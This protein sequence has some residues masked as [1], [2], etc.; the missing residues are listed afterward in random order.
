[1]HS[2]DSCVFFK[3]FGQNG[4]RRNFRNFLPVGIFWS[5]DFGAK[6]NEPRTFKRPCA[7]RRVFCGASAFIPFGKWWGNTVNEQ[8]IKV[9]CNIGIRRPWRSF[10]NKYKQ[11]ESDGITH[12]LFFYCENNKVSGDPTAI[13]DQR[14]GAFIKRFFIDYYLNREGEMRHILSPQS[15]S[16]NCGP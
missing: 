16:Q 9:I 13:F 6:Y 5:A 3:Y 15:P 4:V 2:G 10:G 14:I 12:A 11:R 7:F 8:L 1:M